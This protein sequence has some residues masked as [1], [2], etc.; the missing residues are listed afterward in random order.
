MNMR[1]KSTKGARRRRGGGGEDILFHF[2]NPFLS[3]LVR[4]LERQDLG[5][6]S[7]GMTALR[8]RGGLFGQPQTLP[9]TCRHGHVPLEDERSSS[10]GRHEDLG[11]YNLNPEL[12]GEAETPKIIVERR[13]KL[14]RFKIET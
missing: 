8:L 3:R 11:K 4:V 9:P 14:K 7:V 13:E 10:G 6:V 12:F 5:P 2:L 1:I